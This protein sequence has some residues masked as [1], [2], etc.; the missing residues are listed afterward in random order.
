MTRRIC[1]ML[2]AALVAVV[3]VWAMSRAAAQP[4]QSKPKWYK[5]N[6][7]THTLNSDGDSTPEEVARWYRENRYHF[8]VLTDHNYLTSVE[9][10]NALHGADEKFLV[11]RGE[12]ITDEFEKK[13]LHINGLDVQQLVLPQGGRTVS[14]ALQRDVDAIRAARGVPHINH[15]NFGWAITAE[16]LKPLNNNRLF[17]IYNGH[18][19]V[20]NLG[21]GGLPGLE[22]MWDILLSHGKQLYGIAVDDAHHFKRP[23]D[24]TASRPGQG[25]VMVRAER[26]AS[27][28]ILA[29]L[30]RGDFYASTGV[31]L[32]DY[33][34][35]TKEITIR[36]REVARTKHR[37]QFI[38]RDG[39]LLKEVV[40]NPAT[41]AIRGDE[42]YVRA[43]VIDSNGLF[44][45]TQPVFLTP[46]R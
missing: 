38:G 15:P 37:V 14:E 46:V 34:A 39:R 11:I 36:V 25:W 8:L 17:E 19:Q 27:R 32:D 28:E 2:G 16:D 44:A 10:L 30:E 4:A 20:N 13:P 5:G 40:G 21:G 33:Q 22:E 1:L 3:S 29:A 9:G 43:R 7:H 18:P 6:T 35:S 41:Y 31:E 23:W 12:E 42:G 26:L 24:R 45:W